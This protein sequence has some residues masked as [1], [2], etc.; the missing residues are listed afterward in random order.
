M[1]LTSALWKEEVVV[2]KLR[3]A[4]HALLSSVLAVTSFRSSERRRKQTGRADFGM[5]LIN[6]KLIKGWSKGRVVLGVSV[7]AVWWRI[8]V[9]SLV[10]A[11]PTQVLDPLLVLVML[12]GRAAPAVVLKAAA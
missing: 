9:E 6:L 10:V 8:G 11:A 5:C 7:G 1:P 12:D 2:P 4:I 3:S